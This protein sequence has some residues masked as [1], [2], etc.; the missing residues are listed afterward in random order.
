MP[1]GPRGQLHRPL[2]ASRPSAPPR[3]V[4]LRNRRWTAPETEKLFGARPRAG[5]GV[6]MVS[7]TLQVGKPR[8]GEQGALPRSHVR[9]RQTGVKV[10]CEGK[11]Y[12]GLG[13]RL[14]ACCS[15]TVHSGPGSAISTPGAIS[16]LQASPVGRLSVERLRVPHHVQRPQRPG[17]DWSFCES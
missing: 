11:A 13:T 5:L 12:L 7:A 2:P 16:P 8:H 10:T 14:S 6:G 15:N 4:L 1:P 9:E 17:T 3:K